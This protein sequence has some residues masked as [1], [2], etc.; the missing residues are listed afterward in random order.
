[1]AG[2]GKAIKGL[3]LLGKKVKEFSYKPRFYTKHKGG[4]KQ[5]VLFTRKKGP[6]KG[7]KY[8]LD[9]EKQSAQLLGQKKKKIETKGMSHEEKKKW[10]LNKMSTER[11]KYWKKQPIETVVVKRHGK[12]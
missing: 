11:K 10:T 2:I 7:A 1:M 4:M 9:P 3:G 6:E 8:Q 12:K 5:G